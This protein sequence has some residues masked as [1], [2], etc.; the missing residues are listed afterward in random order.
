MTTERQS[1][2]A[3]YLQRSWSA[4]TVRE[5]AKTITVNVEPELRFVVGANVTR[6]EVLLRHETGLA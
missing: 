3:R 4:A 6:K 5:N 1:T 2:I